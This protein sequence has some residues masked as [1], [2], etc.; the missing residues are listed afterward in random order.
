MAI[1]KIN[2]MSEARKAAKGK[3]GKVA[4]D[5]LL[6]VLADEFVKSHK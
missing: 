4:P 6:R 2:L 1:T 3:P 5:I